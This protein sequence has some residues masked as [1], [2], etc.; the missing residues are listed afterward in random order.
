MFVTY[1]KLTIVLP[2]I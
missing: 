1:A 2:D